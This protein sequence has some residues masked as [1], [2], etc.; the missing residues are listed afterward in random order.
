[1]AKIFRTIALAS[2]LAFMGT[3]ITPIVSTI[4]ADAQEVKKAPKKAAKA[5]KAKKAVK[6]KKTA[7]PK[8]VVKA[9]TAAAAS[10]T[11]G[12]NMYLKGGKCVDARS[13]PAGAKK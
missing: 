1:M 4:T 11:C 9:Q 13:V 7:K 12:T 5:K 6:A 10:K 8:K 2:V 3:T